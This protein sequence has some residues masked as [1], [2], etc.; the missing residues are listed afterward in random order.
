MKKRIL[1]ILTYCFFMLVNTSFAGI[2]GT[3][4]GKI[5]DKKT[6]EPL[7]GANIILVDTYL[8]AAADEK[9]FFLVN[10]IPAGTYKVKAEMIGYT[11]MIVE[12]VTILMDLRTT[13]LFEL[14]PRVLEMQ[15][16]TVTA[17]ASMIQKD[18]TATTHFISR[19]EINQ[20][21]VQSF[22]EIVN[23]QPGVAAGHVRGGRQSEVL[24]LVDGFPIQ[25]VIEGRVGSELPMSSII[26]MTVQTGGFNAE[27][28]NAMS[29]VVNILTQDGN[30]RLSA[31]AEI[32]TQKYQGMRNPF[33]DREQELDWISEMYLGG[34]LFT[35]KLKFYVATDL[36]APNTRWRRENFG[37]RLMI[38]NNSSSQ[39]L[40]LNSKLSYSPSKSLKMR[41]QGL[42]SFWDWKEYDHKWSKNL[43]AI[44]DR[45]K[46][47]YRVSLTTT[48]TL[49]PK[50]FYELR[51]SQ[52]N[53]LK[54]IYGASSIDMAGVEYENNNPLSWV[55]A[56]DYPWWLDHQEIHNTA[57]FDFTSQL[58]NYHQLKTGVEFVYYDLYKKNVQRLEVKTYDPDFPQYISYDTEYQYYPIR[59]AYYIQ[60]KID[61]DGM[62]VNIGLRYDFLDPK[63]E[64]PALEEK[65]Y[66]QRHEWIINHDKKQ[67]ANVK[68]QF[69]PRVG[70]A[71]PM[72]TEQELHVNYGWFFQMP[73]FDYLYTNSNLNLAEGFS[74]LGDPDLKPAKTISYEVSYKNQI[75]EKT[76]FDFTVFN[77]EVSNLVDNNTYLDIQKNS[78]AGTGYSRYV[79]LENVNVWGT[80]I[81]LKRDVSQFLSG[82][83]SYTYMTAKGTGSENT[84]KF[85]W[86]TKDTRVPINEYYL[87]WDQRHTL[88]ANIDIRNPNNW[89]LNLLWR[90][91]SPLPYTEYRGVATEPNNARLK[92]ITMLDLRINKDLRLAG[93]PVSVF[94]EFLNIFDR[95]NLLWVDSD[96][97]KGG[98]L[99]DP[100]A[101]D[102]RYRV[103]F[104]FNAKF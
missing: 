4:A 70:L 94:C 87:S 10:N 91:N 22:T 23:I 41:L 12:D 32:S 47:S 17:N 93:L 95:K 78:L 99:S 75:G 61:Y 7:P 46:K 51:L 59:G 74:P 86:L 31:M 20:L 100:G 81:Y 71:I 97:R 35:Q 53:V 98:I 16:I 104:G 27:Y 3:L 33:R 54:S 29:G 24:Y 30:D 80:E 44:P 25:E 64:R 14:D 88:V 62:I 56:G 18:V 49:S 43:L 28:G 76:L 60:D 36:R 19:Q 90:W 55:I 101:W 96:G 38:Y 84:E 73:L 34:P 5:L 15:E 68:H 37:Q 82:K 48:H 1:V 52:Y 83:I 9:G 2:T 102:E 72:G 8:G 66:G 42:L 69:S 63:A 85:N 58:T 21:P 39:N 50:T 45:S 26:D 65:I 6:K 13:L 67:G 57:K 103:R 40:N 11:S 77:K 89:G 92:V 79:N